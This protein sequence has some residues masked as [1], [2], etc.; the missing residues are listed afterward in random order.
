MLSTASILCP[1]DFSEESRQALRWAS[2]ILQ[3]RGGELTVLTVVEPLLAET[4]G[5][6]LS[7]DL[8]RKE[9]ESAL[10]SFVNETLPNR[11]RTGL[12][13]HLNVATG[14]PS[15]LIL[16]TS[17]TR[18][19][20]LIVMATHG[21]AGIKKWLLGSTTEAVLRQAQCALL[22]IPRGAALHGDDLDGRLRKIALATDFRQSSAA[23]TQWA[24]DIAA[25][26]RIPLVFVHV[27]EPVMVQPQWQALIDDVDSERVAAGQRMLATLSEE[28]RDSSTEQVVAIGHPADA[29]AAA[30]AEHG[31]DLVVM[32]LARTEYAGN[33]LPGSIAYRVLTGGRIAVVAVP[34]VAT[35]HLDRPEAISA[36]PTLRSR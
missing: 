24:L 23:A 7:I 15:E 29:I 3:H 20:Q 1:V 5:I 6:R 25:E 27:V 2:T 31:V 34:A 35:H 17:R 16:Q 22:A 14:S 18:N 28:A 36:P 21:R 12:H 19:T 8:A 30:A 11:V 13:L 26:M 33:Q 9:T 10:R 32:G 4:A